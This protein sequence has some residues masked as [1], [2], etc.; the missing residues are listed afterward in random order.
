MSAAGE[1]G[2]VFCG[3]VAG[4]IPSARIGEDEHAV[5]FLDVAPFTAGHTLV[6]PRRHVPDLLE[7]DGALA[8]M[9]PLV[10]STARLL[11]ERL[12]PAGMTVWQSN[13]AYAGQTVFHLHLHLIPRYRGDGGLQTVLDPNHREISADELAE[14]RDHLL[15]V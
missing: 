11:D 4:D 13:R 5:A 15:G 6:V 9:A 2:C 7:A 3:I 12:Q 1:P 10:E 8:E 14:V